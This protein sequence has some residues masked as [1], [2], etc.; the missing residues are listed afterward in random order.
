MRIRNAIALIGGL[1]V[2]ALALPGCDRDA[3]TEARRD[4]GSV[5]KKVDEALDRTQQRLA[6]AGEKTQRKLSEAGG[7]M[8]PKIAAAG[9]R[10]SAAG[11][12]LTASVKDA[13]TPGEPANATPRA[14]GTEGGTTTTT[15]V[16]TGPRTSLSGAPAATRGSLGDTAI[17]A[18]IKTDFLKDPDLSV[19]KIDVDTRDGVVTLNG[20]A[21]NEEARQ[22]AERLAGAIKGVREVR[23]YLTVKRG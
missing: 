18:S 23:N 11:E 22:R 20:L 1:A 16:T 10:I 3:A 8:Q 15:T 13:A 2:V 17:T 7:R 4:V 5:G 21:D 9:E 14:P 12:K 6:E 19:L